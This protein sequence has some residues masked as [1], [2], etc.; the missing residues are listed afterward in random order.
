MKRRTGKAKRR[1]KKMK[2]ESSFLQIVLRIGLR[3]IAILRRIAWY[4]YNKTAQLA[5][6]LK[7]GTKYLF[8]STRKS[9]RIWNSNHKNSFYFDMLTAP[10]HRPTNQVNTHFPFQQALGGRAACILDNVANSW[11]VKT[12]VSRFT[13]RPWK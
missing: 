9:K 1:M 4:L 11:D 3:Q 5:A 6:G 8:V 10:T 7:S 2:F 12:R 13:A